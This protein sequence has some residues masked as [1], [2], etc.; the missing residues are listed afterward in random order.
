MKKKYYVRQL[1]WS[2]YN[3]K[4]NSKLVTS[5]ERRSRLLVA[6]KCDDKTIPSINKAFSLAFSKLPKAIKPL[7][8]TLDNGTEFL[9]FREIEKENDLTVYFAD[10]HSPWQREVTKTSMV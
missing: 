6:A 2:D 9:G 7:T 5:I 8:L 1:Q 4:C 3:N 10:P